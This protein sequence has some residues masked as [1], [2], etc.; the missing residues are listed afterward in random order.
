MENW[1]LVTFREAA[2]LVDEGQSTPAQLTHVAYIIAH[3]LSH[4]WF[5]NLVGIEWWSQ[6]WLKEGFAT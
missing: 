1:G 5:G 4:M 3:E 2:L 6:L